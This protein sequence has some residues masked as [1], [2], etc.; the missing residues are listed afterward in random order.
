MGLHHQVPTLHGRHFRLEPGFLQENTFQNV[1]RSQMP[2]VWPT[3]HEVQKTRLRYGRGGQ[4][5][6]AA[7]PSAWNTER[8]ME[9]TVLVC[10]RADLFLRRYIVSCI[11]VWMNWKH[12][13]VMSEQCISH[14]Y[15]ALHNINFYDISCIY[16]AQ[17]CPSP[18]GVDSVCRSPPSN[19]HIIWTLLN[20]QTYVK[21]MLLIC[22]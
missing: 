7:I 16:L 3:H 12:I 18:K 17:S 2:H 11:V 15:E 8:Y 5:R 13:G 20:V 19:L 14:V 9:E 4:W 1:R 10:F 6:T 22:L 21:Q